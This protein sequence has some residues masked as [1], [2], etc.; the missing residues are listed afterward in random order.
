MKDLDLNTEL[1]IHQ[2]KFLTLRPESYSKIKGIIAELIYRTK[3]VSTGFVSRKGI[4]QV[5]KGVKSPTTL[6]K[7]H[8]HSR[9]KCAEK[10]MDWFVAN[11]ER[12]SD[13]HIFYKLRKMLNKAR[14][15]HRVTREENKALKKL[16]DNP[17]TRYVN[18]KLQY[19]MCGIELVKMVFRKGRVGSM[20]KIG[21]VVFDSVRV[22][23]ESLEVKVATIYM[24]IKKRKAQY[25]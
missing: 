25:V 15:V 3:T 20:V 24:W 1:I 6:T 22:A 4:E 10:M 19:A 17:E 7:E 8:F 16:Q 14:Y 18:W 23:A 13:Y 2:L 5:E 11:H 9:T 12:F 21:E